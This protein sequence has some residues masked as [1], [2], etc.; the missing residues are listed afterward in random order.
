MSL[1]IATHPTLPQPIHSVE[2]SRSNGYSFQIEMHYRLARGGARI[3]EI[4][5]F[6]LDRTRGESKLNVRIG[7][8]SL[9]MVWWL[10]I[11][12]LLGRL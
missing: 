2:R 7:L 8:E 5:I 11:A 4:P 10:R 1:A 12:D 3:K 6:F 9:W